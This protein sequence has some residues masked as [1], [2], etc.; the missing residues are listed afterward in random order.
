MR[1]NKFLSAFLLLV[2]GIFALTA[3]AAPVDVQVNGNDVTA[4]LEKDLEQLVTKLAKV[5]KDLPENVVQELPKEIQDL[6]TLVTQD[7]AQAVQN[8]PNY[9]ES[10]P[11]ILTHLEQEVPELVKGLEKVVSA[12]SSSSSNLAKRHNSVAVEICAEIKAKL[13]AD[14][15]A[16]ISA[17]VRT[18]QD[19]ATAVVVI[20]ALTFASFIVL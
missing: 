3:T 6:P 19:K 2:L 9:V 17:S 1:F 16:K 15:Y 4:T 11:Q 18:K 12:S 10:L 8:L 7:L 13:C 20:Q 14:L 5:V